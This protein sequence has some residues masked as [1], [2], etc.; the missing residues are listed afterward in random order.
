MRYGLASVVLA[1]LLAACSGSSKNELYLLKPSLSQGGLANRLGRVEV[2]QVALPDYALASEIAVQT[3]D[4]VLRTTKNKLWADK[5]VA[6][7]SQLIADEISTQSK[8]TAIVEPWPLSEPADRRLE[9][10]IT[11]IY[12]GN[13]GQFHL[14]GQYFVA[15]NAGAGS[16]IVRRFKLTTPLADDSFATIVQAQS[17]ALQDLARAVSQ[18]K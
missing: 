12:A 8:A 11:E 4:G 14:N 7:I 9:I 3:P 18:L 6:A 16:D 17:K 13:D 10:R 1:V 2:M 5:P 15:P